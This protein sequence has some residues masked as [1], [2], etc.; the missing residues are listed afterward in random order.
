M[1]KYVGILIR[2]YVVYAPTFLY[3]YVLNYLYNLA[4]PSSY[5]FTG[6]IVPLV[7]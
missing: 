6:F 4:Y 2:W 5:S 1:T 7:L 3:F